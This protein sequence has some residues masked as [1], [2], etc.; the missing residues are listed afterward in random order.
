M[1]AQE[2]NIRGETGGRPVKTD[3]RKKK[4]KR[5]LYWIKLILLLT[6]LSTTVVLLA[7]SPL[8]N[9]KAIV[10]EGN[11]HHTKEE[12]AGSTGIVIGLNGFRQFENDFGS[13]LSLRYKDAEKRILENH[14]YIKDVKVRFLLPDKVKVIVS[15]RE[16][17]AVVHSGDINL[18]I[19]EEG[20]VLEASEETWAGY[21]V[22][23]GLEFSG[24]RPGQALEPANRDR[25]KK[26]KHVLETLEYLDKNSS[27]KIT[28]R[29]D[30]IDVAQLKNICIKFDSRI[31]IK[32][33]DLQDME[34]KVTFMKE[35]LQNKLG[36]HEKGTLDFTT[37]ENPEF[38]PGE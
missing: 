28:E 14:S 5:R 37:G 35:I 19:D 1:K 4:I 2:I 17:F 36:P 27:F 24:F 10:V 3:K 16:P 13:I 20:Y 34:Y 11:M 18:L 23:T 31:L 38:I 15:E 9:I 29:L 12:L 21:P 32:L 22:I 7:L 26:A 30:Y 25:I 6:L 8:F 33:G